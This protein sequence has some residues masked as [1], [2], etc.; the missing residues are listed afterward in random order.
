MQSGVVFL[1]AIHPVIYY[2]LSSL[3]LFLKG[4][5]CDWTSSRHSN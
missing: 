4:I 5:S 3:T 1:L 2:Y